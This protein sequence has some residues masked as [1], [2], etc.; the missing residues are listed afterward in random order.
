MSPKH[1][2]RAKARTRGAESGTSD[3]HS[4]QR[5]YLT[6]SEAR[7][8]PYSGARDPNNRASV[9]AKSK[10]THRKN[11]NPPARGKKKKKYKKTKT[12]VG[13]STK[14]EKKQ[15]S[16]PQKKKTPAAKGQKKK[17][18]VKGRGHLAAA[19]RRQEAPQTLRNTD[20]VEALRTTD[21]VHP[22]SDLTRGA[23]GTTGTIKRGYPHRERRHTRRAATPN[24]HARQTAG[25]GRTRERLRGV[26]RRPHPS[27]CRVRRP[28]WVG[29]RESPDR[30]GDR[31][32]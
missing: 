11:R 19:E 32:Q 20:P 27:Q 5:N 21:P 23:C 3:S 6:A 7:A 28:W 24:Q 12:P 9:A 8:R 25:G 16:R 26:F 17:Q 15:P 13:E 10:Q 1:V 2:G 22:P 31:P 29:H 30:R 4:N 18:Q 14:H